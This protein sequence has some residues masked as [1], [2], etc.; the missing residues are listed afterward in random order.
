MIS[1]GKKKLIIDLSIPRNADPEINDKK[2]IKAIDVDVLSKKTKKT[3]EERKKQIPQV[4]KII[5]K[6]KSEFYEWLMFRRSTPA[7]NSLKKSLEVIQQDAIS[8]H[9][10]KLQDDKNAELIE[11]V[12][13]QMINKIVS[14]FAMHLK[15]ENTQANQSIKVMKDVF[16][17][18]PTEH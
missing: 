6:Y 2:N 8:A 1:E 5:K 17:L 12:T 11:D 7:I 15:S 9:S 4:E 13:S 16:N 14:K 10:K 3:L 18:E